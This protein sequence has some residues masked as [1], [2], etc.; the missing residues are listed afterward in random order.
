MLIQNS[1]FLKN[2]YR[3]ALLPCMLS[4]LSG[5]LNILTDGILVGQRIGIDGLAALSICVPIYLVLCVIGSFFVAGTSIP[6]SEAIG[7][8]NMEQAQQYYGTCLVCCV[9][10]SAFATAIGLLWL[11]SLAVAMAPEENIRIMVQT[12]AGVTIA[13][14]LPKILIY[15]PFWYLRLEGKNRSVTAMMAIMG[16]SNVVLDI[17]F[18]YL[19]NMGVFG[20]ALASVI[21]TS[22]ASL[23]GFIMLHT[24]H[25]NFR[26]R[27]DLLRTSQEWK[28]I[29]VSG[30]P[31]ALNN[32]LQT[33]RILAVN[34]ILYQ[35]GQ[36]TLVAV[37]TATNGIAAFAEAVTVGVPNAGTAML[38]VYHGERDNGSSRILL[39]REWQD[40]VV[41][42][43]IS[44]IVIVVFS[45]AIQTA[46]GL[47]QVSVFVPML[48][49]AASLFPGLWNNMMISFYNVSCHEILSDLLIACRVFIFAIL[50]LFACKALS[51]S[52]W[53]FLPLSEC[54][55]ILF[56]LAATKIISCRQKNCTRY[57]LMDTTLEES[58]QVIN[59]TLPGE[60]DEIC[61][62]CEKISEFC[63]KNGMSPKQYMKISLSMEEMMTL[64]VQVNKGTPVSF[65]LRVY[66]LT[67]SLGI[68][69]RY[70]GIAFNPVHA[71]ECKDDAYM[72]VR[73]LDELVNEI[74]YRKVFGVNT[75]II[76]I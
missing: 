14:A 61:S 75:L 50:S 7:E 59:F 48:C 66:S 70:D 63:S 69:I 12:Y 47:G 45:G 3:A 54:L 58:G 30:S 26:L 15:V 27:P 29:P 67:D 8:D 31:A 38:G 43:A 24:G 39:K 72:G 28:R 18:M 6:A 33:I 46:Y 2:E 21:A 9:V 5:C 36:S 60:P 16:V 34:A 37:F 53:L 10:A 57:L 17:V 20:A 11:P 19:M 73:M 56:W 68:R 55:T 35:M 32:F 52:V 76:S 42:A 51:I 40:G 74:L 71:K 62:A 44:G 65:D 64:I 1:K 4:I 22:C 25:T 13:G 23:F 41:L 49:L